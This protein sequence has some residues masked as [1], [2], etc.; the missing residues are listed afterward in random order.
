LVHRL[1]NDPIDHIGDTIDRL[2][3]RQRHLRN[4]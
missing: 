3:P 4:T 2:H 1:L